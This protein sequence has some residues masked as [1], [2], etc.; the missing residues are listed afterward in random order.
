MLREGGV[1][2]FITSQ[3]FAQMAPFSMSFTEL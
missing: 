1:L 3:G 2:A